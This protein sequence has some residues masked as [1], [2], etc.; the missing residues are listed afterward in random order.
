MRFIN[1]TIPGKPNLLIHMEERPDGTIYTT[2]QLA[3]GGKADLRGLFFDVR[4]AGLIPHL[5][6]TGPAVT[7]ALFKNDGVID[8]GHGANVH[9]GG[10]KPFDVGIEFGTPGNKH[11]VQNTSFVLTSKVGGLTLDDVALVQFGVRM[12]GGGQPSKNLFLAPAAP[13]AIDD[14]LTAYEDVP[15]VMKVLANDTDEDG[16]GQFR[17]VSVSDPVHG[18]ATISADGKSIIYVSDDDYSG[19]D[20]F[21]YNMVDGHGG[22]DSARATVNVIAVADAPDLTVATAPGANVNEIQLTVSAAVTDTDGSEYIDRFVF[23]GL[24]AGAAIVGEGDLVFNPLSTTQTLSRTFTLTL[25]PG[26]DFDFDLGVKAVARELSNGNEKGTL[27]LLPVAIDAN[28]TAFEVE[29]EAVDQ[30]MWETGDAFIVED[31][32]FLGVDLNSGDQT[33]DAGIIQGGASLK[34]KTGLHSQLSINGG[35]IDAVL[36]YDIVIDTTYNRVT[37]VLLIE[38]FAD[39][40]SEDGGF[41]TDAPDGHY[42]LDFIFNWAIK[43]NIDLDID[44]GILGSFNETLWSFDGGF[45]FTRNI[46]DIDSEDIGL[47]FE[48]PFGFSIELAWPDV[49]TESLVSTT[50]V[51]TSSGASNNFLQ[52]VLDVDQALADIFLGGANPFQIDIEYGVGSG[53]IEL[54]DVDLFGGANFLQSFL[55]SV[56]NLTGTLTFENGAERAWDFGDIVLANASSYDADSDGIVEF[57][58]EL[59]PAVTMTNDIDLGFNIGYRVDLLKASGDYDVIFTSGEWEVGPVWEADGSLPLGSIDL[60]SMEFPLAFTPQTLSFAGNELPI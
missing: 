52:L 37:D 59:A 12:T 24:P 11:V 2:L 33:F 16:K 55:M 32:R 45:D 25:A 48:F 4:D 38:S 17:I 5:K 22:G 51:F 18:T 58:L 27:K 40:L 49:D 1:F 13:N 41:S 28:S 29:F 10:R 20:S 53:S 42:I 44:L 14:A 31:D 9:G 56:G 3:G 30:S 57:S 34:L 46:L 60:V 35:Q 50:N 15:K 39:L 6:V 7:K 43:A 47:E 19:P 54:L 8:L 26:T 23:S 21:T 36:P